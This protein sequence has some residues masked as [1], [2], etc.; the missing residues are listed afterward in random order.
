M[1]SI[2]ALYC[3][4]KELYSTRCQSGPFTLNCVG[5]GFHCLRSIP[6]LVFPAFLSGIACG[7]T[8]LKVKD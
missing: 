5:S 7:S 2:V 4:V 6:L 1:D 8:I 3:T